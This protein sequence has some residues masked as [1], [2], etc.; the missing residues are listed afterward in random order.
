ML[1]FVPPVAD[2]APQG[3]VLLGARRDVLAGET[4]AALVYRHG[5]HVVSVFVRP[6]PGVPDGVEPPASI[7]GFN[8]LRRTRGGMA[9]C[10][11]SDMARPEMAR[12]AELLVAQAGGGAAGD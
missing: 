12:L 8:V 11:V 2:F 7:R 1:N 3:F 5:A 9:F 4:A 6:A 10:L